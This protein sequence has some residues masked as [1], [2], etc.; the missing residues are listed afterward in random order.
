MPNNGWFDIKDDGFGRI[1]LDLSGKKV[2]LRFT[3]SQQERLIQFQ[4]EI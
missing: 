1:T 3:V 2:P 4:E